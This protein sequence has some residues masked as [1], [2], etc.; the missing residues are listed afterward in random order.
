MKK[1]KLSLFEKYFMII[2]SIIMAVVL[3][4]VV[5]IAYTNLNKPKADFD[6]FKASVLTYIKN[7]DN[8]VDMVIEDRDIFKIVVKD[9][10]YNSSEAEKLKFCNN[11][12]NTIYAYAKQYKLIY[13]ENDY[14]Y[15]TFCDQSN[16]KLAEPNKFDFV[17]L[18]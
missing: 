3:I 14:V 4:V 12:R 1:R 6:G 10:W 13:K 7:S 15:I 11:V 2:V 8:I 5:S 16:I 9:T 18:R 17:I